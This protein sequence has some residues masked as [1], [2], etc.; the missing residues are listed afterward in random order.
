MR[1]QVRYCPLVLFF[2]FYFSLSLCTVSLPLVPAGME[3]YK[4]TMCRN[5]WTGWKGF[6]YKLHSATESKLSHHEAQKV[7]K[8][9]GAHL[10]SLHSIEDI[11]MLHTNFHAGKHI[12]LHTVINN[13]LSIKIIAINLYLLVILF[14]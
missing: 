11:E 2:F 9:D 1:V 5:S 13:N 12:S 8:M 7:C 3:V 4:P 14:M 6:C 10:A